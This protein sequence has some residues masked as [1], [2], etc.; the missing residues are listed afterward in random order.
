MV[1]PPKCIPNL[2]CQLLHYDHPNKT[3]HKLEARLPLPDCLQ[4]SCP[5]YVSYSIKWNWSDV[6]MSLNVSCLWHPYVTRMKFLII[7]QTI[8][9]CPANLPQHSLILFLILHTLA[10]LILLPFERA[11]LL[12]ISG[13][14]CFLSL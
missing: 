8:W 10:F 11:R 7:A 5:F 1:L 3:Q 9:S 12:L 14:L 13:P 2:T 6:S 4:L